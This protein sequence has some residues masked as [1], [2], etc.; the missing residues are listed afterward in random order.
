MNK[1]YFLLTFFFIG[2]FQS[3]AQVVNQKK[4][5]DNE[6][7]NLTILEDNIPFDSYG[8]DLSE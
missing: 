5:I 6:L 4:W 3:F 2:Y 1:I 7:S 8:C